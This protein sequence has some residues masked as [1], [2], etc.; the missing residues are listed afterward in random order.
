MIPK[1]SASCHLQDFISCCT[2]LH[3]LVV[4]RHRDRGHLEKKALDLWFQKARVHDGGA[5]AW[6]QEQLERQLEDH[7]LIRK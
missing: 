4:R 5:E 3:Y 2:A 7:I 6:Q 1:G